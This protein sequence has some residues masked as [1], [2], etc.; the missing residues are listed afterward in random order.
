[1]SYSQSFMKTIAV[2][3]SG[4]VSYPP[5]DQGGSV[6]YSGVAY[7]DVKVEVNV[8]TKYFD[9]SISGCNQAIDGLTGSVQ[10]MNTA[11]CLAIG[12]QSQDISKSIIRGF[13]NTI[14]TDLGTQKAELEQ[15]IQAKLILLQKQKQMLLEKRQKMEADYN[16][17][18]ERYQKIFDDLNKEL[19]HRIHQI[20][21]PVF[22]LVQN[23]DEQNGKM[24]HTDLVQT[25]LTFNEESHVS[26]SQIC[27][28]NIKRI[29]SMS[30][31]KAK[32]FI[33]QKKKT[34]MTI[35]R[36]T[37]EGSGD[38]LICLPV[39]FV[40]TTKDNGDKK[41][42]CFC[43]SH[44]SEDIQDKVFGNIF[45]KK[46]HNQIVNDADEN[47][48]IKDLVEKEISK[49]LPNDDSHSVRLRET[50]KKLISNNL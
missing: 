13:F 47:I 9:S 42:K 21:Q 10:T 34:E 30:I 17:T 45:M 48:I 4:T 1:M 14:K 16:R 20:D 41:Q 31:E 39:M 3:Y 11:Q 26:Q 32:D 2:H 37:V 33:A 44:F 15:K 25:A 8:D 28:A 29:S 50:I 12:K 36:T 24:M 6:S 18:A 43:P 7:E 27:S 23:I 19:S 35:N 49:N 22:S 38:K 40:E 46:Q 5:S